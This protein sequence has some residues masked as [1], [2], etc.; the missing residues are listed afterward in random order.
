MIHLAPPQHQEILN[1][2]IIE[3]STYNTTFG[4][5]WLKKHDPRINYKKRIIKFENCECQPKLKIQKISLR[6]M[7]AFYK[8]DPNSVILAIIFI[9][10]RPDKF[11]LLF[12]KYRRFKSL[13]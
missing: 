5:P 8:K 9:E 2:D 3:T 12:K 10:K 4:L 7:A 6:V 13:F 11:K 1:L